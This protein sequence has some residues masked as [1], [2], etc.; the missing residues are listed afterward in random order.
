MTPITAAVL[1]FEHKTWRFQGAKEQAI[2]D[3]FGVSATRYYAA[4]NRALDDPEALALDG[5]LVNRLRRL[6]ET[7]RRAHVA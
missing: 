6:R 1:A 7:R 2:K 4:L 5:P 3:T